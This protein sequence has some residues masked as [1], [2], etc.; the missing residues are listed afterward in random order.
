[1]TITKMINIIILNGDSGF[2][3]DRMLK[4]GNDIVKEITWDL[5]FLAWLNQCNIVTLY[6][7]CIV[8]QKRCVCSPWYRTRAT[9]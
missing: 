7:Q 2:A 3:M 6:Q 9:E 8:I 4:S 5:L 1:M